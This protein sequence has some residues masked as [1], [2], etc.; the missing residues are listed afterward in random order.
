MVIEMTKILEGIRVLDLSQVGV[1]P[2]C[3]RI[4][5]D[6]GAEVIKVEIPK[7]GEPARTVP[8][9]LKGQSYLFTVLNINKKSITLNL[10]SE[11][12]RDIS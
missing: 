9:F 11:K 8:P 4:L 3:T 6:F 1:G 5:G 2:M 12:G 10:R 7:V